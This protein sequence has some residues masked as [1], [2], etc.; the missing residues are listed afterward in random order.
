MKINENNN[1]KKIF[2]CYTTNGLSY[3]CGVNKWKINI[4][5]KKQNLYGWE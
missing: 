1:D 2:I 4:L 5:L 3:D